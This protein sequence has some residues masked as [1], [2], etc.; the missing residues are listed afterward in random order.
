[1]GK[2]IIFMYKYNDLIF[3]NE[4]NCVGCNKCI[5]EC[6]VT[7]ANI[8]YIVNGQNKVKINEEMCI[9]CGECIKICG[10][11]ARQF[12]DDT[13]QFL[14]DLKSGRKI[15]LIVAPSIRVNLE[16][17]KNLFGYFKSLGVNF[18]YDVSFGADITVWAY[19]KTIK[20]NNLSS[21]IAQPCSSVINYIEKYQPQLTDY[22]APVHSPMMC[23][24]I[25]MKKHSGITDDLAFISPCISKSD[26]IYDKNTQGYVKYNVTFKKISDYIKKNNI[27]LSNFK[28]YDY[29]DIGC[30]LG[31]LFSRPGGLRENV[32][33]RM[34]DV[35]IRQ[36]EGQ[37]C[38]YK[39]LDEYKERIK[40]KKELP[41]LV[42]ILNCSNGCNYGT[43]AWDNPDQ[44]GLS[45]DDA[46]IKFNRLKKIKSDEKSKK[47]IKKKKDW[48]FEMFENTL[49]IADFSR[50][51]NKN[52][53]IEDIKEPSEA[54]YDE[55]FA[56]LNKFT[57]KQKNINCSTCGYGEC[58][59]MAKAIFNNL[60]V[61]ENCIDYNRQEVNLEQKLVDSKS[62][63]M[64]ILE[65]LNRLSEEKL[66]DAEY[67]KK[68]VSE[69][70]SSIK[71]ISSGNE[72]SA[73]AIGKISNEISDILNMSD[74]LKNSVYE[75]HE[76]IEKFSEASAQIVGI[77]NQTNLLSLNAAIEAARAQEAGKGFSV[78]AGEIK[79][80]SAKSKEV[81]A[82]T[83]Q[84]QTAMLKFMDSIL[85]ISTNLESK[86][87]LVNEAVSNISAAIQE[88]TAN[89]E[90]V[91][92][93]ASSLI[94]K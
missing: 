70:I 69:I 64:H 82:S 10:H 73:A 38:A 1:M 6:P 9:H 50:Y 11:S 37:S 5:K 58:R 81:A 20:Y 36:V 42:D 17:Y 2:G 47:I 16:N 26:E 25:Y 78:V 8:A 35:W 89:S 27:N 40:D 31:F 74:I 29:D 28:E 87:A 44:K 65:D 93:S 19:L 72:E 22:L 12:N 41:F 86:M 23:T 54:E 62:D 76:K 80:L 33:L 51:Y 59:I 43:A 94:E 14:A 66:K 7:G 4:D 18:I 13:E 56:K 61:P 83:Q 15:S 67:L 57:D 63:Q 91:N 84:D 21:V 49:N 85:E 3:I 71:Q 46:D 88:I 92:V 30:S 32:E 34:K 39:Y 68:K 45:V 52:K 75:M 77:A 55:I 79:K 24:A 60:N 53:A 90:E 48:L